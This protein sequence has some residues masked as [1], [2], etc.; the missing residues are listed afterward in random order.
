MAGFLVSGATGLVGRYVLEALLDTTGEEVHAL[1]RQP[2]P[3]PF[4][5]H[6]RIRAWQADLTNAEQIIQT[7]REARPAVVI[8]TAALADVDTCERDHALAH[9]VNVEGVAHMAR[10]CVAV[11]AHLVHVS[12][13]YVFDGSEAA[14]GP[15]DETAATHPINYYGE[16]K[17]EAERAVHAICAGRVGLAICRTAWVY[18]INPAGRAN[19]LVGMVNDLRAG[20][21]VRAVTD[22]HNTP[23]PAANLAEMLLAAAQQRAVG[24]FHT[25]GGERSTRYTLALAVAAHF[26]LDAA[27]ITPLR[28]AELGQPA[29]RPLRGGLRVEKAERELGVRAWSIQQGLNWLHNRLNAYQGS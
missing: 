19:F 18:G 17:L 13:D 9:A 8:H 12:T 11:G 22:Q 10:A 4:N 1:A 7:L 6:P 2:L 25:A 28:S 26:G 3:T 23:T 20:R 21:R 27:L 14:P 29:R 24:L 5:T 15:Y 16:T